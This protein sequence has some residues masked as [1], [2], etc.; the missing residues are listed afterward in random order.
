MFGLNG[1][2][3]QI[4]QQRNHSKDHKGAKVDLLLLLSKDR[5]IITMIG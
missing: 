2:Y 1:N 3:D 4:D 5:I